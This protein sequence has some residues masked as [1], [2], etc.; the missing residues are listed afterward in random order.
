MIASSS[1]TQA[2]RHQPPRIEAIDAVRGLAMV[3][4]AL[5]HLRDFLFHAIDIDPTDLNQT[6]PL[7]FMTRWISHLCAPTFIF[8]AG[9]SIYLSMAKGKSR[10]SMSIFLI[11]RGLW[12]IFL[13]LLVIRSIGWFFNFDYHYLP[14]W[15]IWVLG[16]SM[17][18][19]AA[20]IHWPRK[21]I[22]CVSLICIF[23]HNLFDTWVTPQRSAWT[24]LG[25]TLHESEAL[26]IPAFRP[27]WNEPIEWN[28]GYPLIP[29]VAVMALGY[30]A[31]PI[32]MYERSKRRRTL[33]VVG[34]L[35]MV[36]FVGIRWSQRYGEP[37][38]WVKF[39]DLRW[40]MMSFLN[41]TKQP[42]SLAFLLMT[43]GPAC[44]LLGLWD[45][46]P[47]Y[48][49]CRVLCTYGRV[50][51]F[52]YLLHLPL[53]HG[54][55]LVLSRWQTGT[56]QTWLFQNPPGFFERNGY[57]VDLIGVYGAWVGVLLLMYPMCSWYGRIKQT[58]RISWL[59]YL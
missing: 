21:W 22:A 59:S 20:L 5:D 37:Q 19:L 15:V 31:G 32:F 34:L 16:W 41:C 27:F 53:I 54:L 18:L 42:P 8:L 43:L 45:R 11:K 2:C 46:E 38:P 12:M 24:W 29:W 4:M 44:L 6:Y 33:I 50:P 48:P 25:V 49:W 23:G 3:L 14:A 1:S 56:F 28:A 7:L 9:T 36:L 13:E 47:A 30:V 26:I 35:A 52:Y 17:L 55:A 58:Y 39:D 51:L 57:G 40:T 10:A